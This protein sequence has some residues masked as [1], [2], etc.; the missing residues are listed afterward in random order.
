MTAPT[1]AA[2]EPMRVLFVT[3]KWPPAVGGMETYSVE[4]ANELRDLVD[5]ELQTLAGRADGRPPAAPALAWFLFTSAVMLVRRR[6]DFDLV[7]F[8]DFVLFPLAWLH[9]LV[10]PGSARAVTVHGLDLIYGN[11]PGL[12]ARVYRVFMGFARQ[13]IGSIDLVLANSRNTADIARRQGLGDAVVVPLGVR[14]EQATPVTRSAEQPAETFILFVGRLVP[15]KG[16]AWFAEQVLPRLGADLRLK[17]VGKVWDA[18]EGRRLAAQP[19]VELVGYVS[20]EELAELRRRALAVV[21]PNIPSPGETDVEGFGITALEAAAS[22]APLI[23]ARIEGITDAVIDGET[24]FLEPALDVDRWVARISDLRTWT[25]EQRAA[26]T[27]R[28]RDAIGEHYAWSRV[29]RDT[30]AAY[31]KVLRR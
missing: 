24:G 23:A 9:A 10:A 22:G 13:R 20:D 4:L 3:R 31:R 7:H 27:A 1:E 12:A 19:G 11:R 28:A 6:R 8:G 29:A 15:R 26:F 5:L 16:A 30:V 14:L 25:P 17:V 18:E 21:M 2:Q